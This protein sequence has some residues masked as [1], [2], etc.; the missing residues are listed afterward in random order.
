M[1]TRLAQELGI[2]PV[3]IRRRNIYREGSIEPTNQ[4]L[5]PGVSALTRIRKLY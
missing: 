4:P 2:D 5:P 1:V 3:D